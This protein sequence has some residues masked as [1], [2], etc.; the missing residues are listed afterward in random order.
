MSPVVTEKYSYNQVSLN[1]KLALL[2]VNNSKLSYLEA[3]YNGVHHERSERTCPW[4]GIPAAAPPTVIVASGPLLAVAS[5][6]VTK[7]LSAE[8]AGLVC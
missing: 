8:T 5:P 7:A 4:L 6:I 3:L 1:T 2:N